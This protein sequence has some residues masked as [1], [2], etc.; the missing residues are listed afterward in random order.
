ML[1]STSLNST[2]LNSTILTRTPNT[3]IDR[4]VQANRGNRD[5][6]LGSLFPNVILTRYNAEGN[7]ENF[8]TQAELLGKRCVIFFIPGAWTPVCTKQHLS[9]YVEYADKLKAL[10]IDKIICATADYIDAATEWNKIKGDPNKIEIWADNEQELTDKTGLG[11]NNTG[12]RGQGYAF[13]RV[14]MIVENATVKFFEI[15]DNRAACVKS[16]AD[17]IYKKLLC[18]SKSHL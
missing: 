18:E 16:H 5:T 14:A 13:E 7:R 1:S 2:T 6:L 15:E 11:Y 3:E 12:N 4:R 10:G 17:A 9:G 8:S